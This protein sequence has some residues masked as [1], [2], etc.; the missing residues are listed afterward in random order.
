MQKYIENPLLI[1]SKKFDAR[2]YVLIYGVEPMHAYLCDEGL[3]RFCTHNY[4]RPHVTNMKNYYMH[5]TN[6]SINK[7]SA[8]FKLPDETFL[9]DDTSHKQPFTNVLKQLI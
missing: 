4:Q 8:K 6:F 7:K 3:A 1:Q 9:N 2:I 5:L